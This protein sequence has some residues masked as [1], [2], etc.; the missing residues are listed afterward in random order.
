MEARVSRQSFWSGRRVLI[1]GCSGFLGSWLTRALIE[2]G[3]VVAGLI[4]NRSGATEP[5]ERIPGDVR[6]LDLLERVSTSSGFRKIHQTL[7]HSIQ[8]FDA[9]RGVSQRLRN[10]IGLPAD[11][12]TFVFEFAAKISEFIEC[13]VNEAVHGGHG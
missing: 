9:S 5:I 1:T 4:R 7:N 2:D 13:Y 12:K 10:H 6:D 8:F 11:R 3:A